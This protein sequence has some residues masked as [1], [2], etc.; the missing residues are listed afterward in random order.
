MNIR[1]LIT[2]SRDWPEGSDPQR[3][4]VESILSSYVNI[5]TAMGHTTTIVVGDCP[6]GV[7]AITFRYVMK[8]S[9]ACEKWADG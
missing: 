6:T 9:S 3:W 7:D 4:R 2:G 1:V 5:A 8:N